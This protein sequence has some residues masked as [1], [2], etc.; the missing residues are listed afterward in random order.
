MVHSHVASPPPPPRP[1]TSVLT[2]S[3]SPAAAAG[4]AVKLA[5]SSF[6]PSTVTITSFLLLELPKLFRRRL[7]FF[8]CVF[9]EGLID[10]L[11]RRCRRSP[12]LFLDRADIWVDDLVDTLPL[13]HSSPFPVA[14]GSRDRLGDEL[15]RRRSLFLSRSR[16][17]EVACD[18]LFLV[19]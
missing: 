2:L 18:D 11:C 14:G 16:S 15:C 3:L 19:L 10:G 5:P 12:F 6:F 13:S 1:P 7:F 9:R 8:L 4:C 17:G